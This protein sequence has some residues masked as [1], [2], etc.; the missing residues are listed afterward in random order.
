MGTE[1]WHSHLHQP[2]LNEVADIPDADYERVVRRLVNEIRSVSP[3]RVIMIDGLQW[4]GRPLL[5]INDLPQIIQCGR[6]YQPMIISH[7]EASWVF[8]NR[9]MQIPRE[10]LTWPLDLDGQHYDK[11]WLQKMLHKSWTP[12]LK[13][14]GRVFIGEFGSHNRTFPFSSRTTGDGP[15]G[16]FPARSASW[17]ATAKMLIMKTSTVTSWIARC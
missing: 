16:I 13:Q 3:K 5:S 9:P 4:G 1:I 12:L 7:Y 17:T 15:C 11:T 8:G 14:G 6:G 2:V 10:Q